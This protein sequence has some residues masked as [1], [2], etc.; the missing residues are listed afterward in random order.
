MR[1]RIMGS[2]SVINDR[3]NKINEHMYASLELKKSQFIGL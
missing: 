3:V 1:L 2:F